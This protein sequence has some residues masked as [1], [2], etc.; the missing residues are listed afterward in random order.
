MVHMW[1]PF[2]LWKLITSYS[3]LAFASESKLSV[4][5]MRDIWHNKTSHIFFCML[6]WA[7]FQI[8]KYTVSPWNLHW[9]TILLR[10]PDCRNIL[11]QMITRRND[12]EYAKIMVARKDTA[13]PGVACVTGQLVHVFLSNRFQDFATHLKQALCEG[14]CSVKTSVYFAQPPSLMS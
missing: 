3:Y 13:S 12:C 7:V 6:F 14:L 2:F 1:V 9:T 10:A 4:Q 11:I 8:K 5:N